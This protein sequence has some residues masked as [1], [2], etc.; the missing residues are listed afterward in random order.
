MQ[1]TKITIRRQEALE[2]GVW[3]LEYGLPV[4]TLSTLSTLSILSTLSRGGWMM[5]D[6]SDLLSSVLTTSSNRHSAES[7]E[8]LNIYYYLLFTIYYL[9]FITLLSH[10]YRVLI[11][12][13]NSN[14]SCHWTTA[15]CLSV[16]AWSASF[17][18]QHEVV[19]ASQAAYYVATRE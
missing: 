15:R 7:D 12:G 2:F 3:N 14:C 19:Y 13:N 10:K 16:K 18:K 1:K 6:V 9:L 17:L 8:Y 5:D 4:S 11:S